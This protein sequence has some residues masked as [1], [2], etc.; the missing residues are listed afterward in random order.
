MMHIEKIEYPFQND[1]D[2][3]N[4][5]WSSWGHTGSCQENCGC[6]NSKPIKGTKNEHSTNSSSIVS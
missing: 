6:V 5:I 2:Y 3:W 1:L 4:Q